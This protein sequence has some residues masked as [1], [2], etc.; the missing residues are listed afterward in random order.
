M[1]LIGFAVVAVVVGAFFALIAWL[2]SGSGEL[3]TPGAA[4]DA[5]KWPR[6]DGS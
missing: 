2:R 6:L 5:D 1:D 4:G 3:H